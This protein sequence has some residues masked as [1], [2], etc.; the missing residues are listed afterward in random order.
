MANSSWDQHSSVLCLSKS[1]PF[2]VG[3]LNFWG[4]GSLDLVDKQFLCPSPLPCSLPP[5]L[6]PSFR[7]FLPPSLLAVPWYWENAT[8]A[9][10]DAFGD[11]KIA[12]GGC[13]GGS[14]QIIYR[15]WV[16]HTQAQ[17]YIRT[18]PTHA[19]TIWDRCLSTNARTMYCLSRVPLVSKQVQIHN[20]CLIACTSNL[21]LSKWMSVFRRR[22]GGVNEG[23]GM[24]EWDHL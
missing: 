5:S 3:W 13:R 1:Y 20:I 4:G 14:Q 16:T 9:W 24:G 6:P 12:E 21:T 11:K 17:T 19:H 23:R 15:E 18:S 2:K 10:K 8:G 7:F 22:E